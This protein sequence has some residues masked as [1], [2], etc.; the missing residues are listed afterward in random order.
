MKILLLHTIYCLTDQS[1][2]KGLDGGYEDQVACR[3][4]VTTEKGGNKHKR[5]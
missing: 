4:S 5:Q 1:G 3:G 2:A